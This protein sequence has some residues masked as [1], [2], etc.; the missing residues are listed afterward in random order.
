MINIFADRIQLDLK[1]NSPLG[2]IDEYVTYD[3]FESLMTAVKF[4]NKDLPP[5]GLNFVDVLLDDLEMLFKNRQSVLPFLVLDCQFGNVEDC[6]K[7][8]EGL[9]RIL[10]LR[11]LRVKEVQF[12]G[13]S[14]AQAMSL[15]TY[16]DQSEPFAV[17]LVDVVDPE[18][19]DSSWIGLSEVEF[20]CDGLITFQIGNRT[21]PSSLLENEMPVDSN[22]SEI[23]ARTV[24]ENRLSMELILRHLQCFDIERLRKVNRGVRKCVDLI[25]P[26]PHIETY[27]ISY[28]LIFGLRTYIELENG[29]FESVDYPPNNGGYISGGSSSGGSSYGGSSSGGSSS[30]GSSISSSSENEKVISF[31]GEDYKSICFNDIEKTLNYQMECM[32]EL[33]IWYNGP[34]MTD[35]IILT[36]QMNFVAHLMSIGGGK[37]PEFELM[38]LRDHHEEFAD[39]SRRIGEILKRRETPLKTRKF[40]MGPS[41][42]MEVMEILPAIDSNYLKCIELLFPS[43][44]EPLL[45]H[46]G[47]TELPFQVDQLSQIIQWKNAE[48]L[49]SKY[50]TITT[51][52]QE[53]NIL[54]FVN[55][56]IL[57]KTLSSE[58]V[59]Y[60]KTKL[61]N[62]PNFQKFK[63]WFRESAIDESLTTL[64]GAPYRNFS[65]VKK[66][67]YFRIEETNH[68]I[69]IVLD[70]REV[71]DEEGKM[72]A[73]L[74]T[75]TRVPEEDTPFFGLPMN[76]L[77]I[78]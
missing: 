63:I 74:I 78:N 12:V 40:S 2:Q 4:G 42:Q 68:Y 8:C 54:H 18:N 29:E 60:L 66:I 45:E 16:F 13:T 25:K 57:V 30:G 50:L 62:S 55:L 43:E 56:D 23:V 10:K 77:R 51:P 35:E 28:G 70:T 46:S 64:I 72:N 49:I 14:V 3:K 36:N 61:L 9:E 31:P 17:E 44:Y 59:F 15:V 22:M 37:L 21:V 53:M 24:L 52:I 34:C 26:N 69:H 75:F 32:K 67:W 48:D 71:K 6:A 47:V 73:K 1:W 5:I 58:D 19:F 76:Q 20:E 11:T 7:I 41:S 33:T 39:L 38:H 27:S 65:D